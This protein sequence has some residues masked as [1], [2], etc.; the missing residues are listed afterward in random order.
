MDFHAVEAGGLG[1]LGTTAV[2]IDDVGDLFGLQRARGR[3]VAER[4]HQADMA[5]GLD[6]TGGHGQLTVQVAGVGDTAHVPQLQEDASARAVHG[7]GDVVPATHLFIVPD[8]RGIRVADAHRR[9]RGRF[10]EDQPGAGALDVVLGHQCIGH[11]ALVG[12]AA[13]QRRHDD[14]V[15]QLQVAERDRVE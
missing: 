9:D 15:G 6:G 12:A 13:G 14:A 8:T 10:A 7:L 11:A 2:G 3:V 5:F 1:V 4:A